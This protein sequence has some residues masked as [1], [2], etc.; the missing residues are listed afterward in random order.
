MSAATWVAVG[1]LGG[2]GALARFGVDLAVL[3][4]A[5]QAFPFGILVVNLT[6]AFAM[7]VL[8]GTGPSTDVMRLAG[9]ATLG[10]YTTFSTWMLNTRR[11]DEDGRRRRALV[12]LAVSLLLGL[13]AVWAGRAL[14]RAIGS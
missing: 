14:G 3:R 4:R 12:N 9:T 11:L 8:V 6:G 2:V 7:G 5:G 13:L 1:A 10:A